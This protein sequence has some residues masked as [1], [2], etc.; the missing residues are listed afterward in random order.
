MPAERIG[1]FIGRA[2]FV[3]LIVVASAKVGSQFG[4]G[5]GLS[6]AL[7][8]LALNGICDELMRRRSQK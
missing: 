2:L 7:A 6:V 4:W 8:L 3:I 1:S 5:V